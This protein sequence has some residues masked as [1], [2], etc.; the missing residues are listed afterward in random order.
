VNGTPL[1]LDAN[2][3]ATVTEAQAGLFNVVATATDP[4]GNTGRATATLTVIDPTD[5]QA[6]VVSLTTP[7]DGAIITAPT[8][9]IGTANDPQLVLYKLEVAPFGT[10]QFTEIARGTSSVVNGTLGRF[11]PTL[12]QNDSYTLRL[13][14]QNAGGHVATVER[15]VSVAGNLKLGNFTLT[16]TDLTVPVWGIPITITRTYDTLKSNTQDGLGYG[17]RLEFR[18]TDLHT[19]IPRTGQEADG[20]FNPIQD[21]TRVYL[22]EPGGR[23]VGFTF[24]PTPSDDY[25]TA[26]GFPVYHPAFVADAGVTDTLTVPDIQLVKQGDQY[27][28]FLGDTPYNP[29]DPLFGATYTLATRNGTAFTIDPVSGD[30]TSA[31]DPN[32]NTLTYSDAGVFSPTGKQVTLGRDAQ[33]RIVSVTD[34]LGDQIAYQYDANGDLVAATDRLGNTTR[35][36]YSTARPHYLQQVVGPQGGAG[37]RTEYDDQ[38]RLD[39]VIDP[40]G[41]AV[42]LN[43]DPNNSVETVVDA[44]GN[45]TR[46]Q[47]DDRGNIVAEVD[48]QGGVTRRTYDAN[49]NLLSETDPLGRTTVRTYD[50]AGNLLTMTDPLGNTTRSTYGPAGVLLTQTDALGETLTNTYDA[51]NH[52]LSSTDAAGNT[53]T[54]T[55]DALGRLS[56]TTDPAGNITRF[57]YDASGDEV[58]QTDPLGHETQFTYDANGNLLTQSTTVTT[59]AG[60]RTLVTTMAYDAEG[61]VTSTTDPEGHTTQ[62]RYDAL[63]NT[64][65]TT[66]PLGHETQFRYDAAGHKVETDFPDGISTLASFDAA[67]RQVSSTDQAGRITQFEYDSLGRQ[68]ATIYS[69]SATTRTEYNAAGQVTAQIDERGNRTEFTYDGDGRQVGVRNALGQETQTTYDAA[70]RVTA[71]TD[72]LGHTAQLVLDALGRA[73]QTVFADGSRTST[74]YDDL[75]RRT[76]VT[77]QAG[78]T[79]RF[80]YDPLGRLTAVVDALNRRTQY[81]Y[82]EVGNLVSQTDANGD[83]TRYEYDGVGHT[84]ATVLPLGQRAVTAYDAAGNVVTTTDY[85]GATIRYEYDANNRLTAKRLPDGTAFV[86]TYTPTGQRATVTDARGVTAYAYDPRDRLLSRTDPDGTQV[87]YSYDAAG[88]RTTLTDPAGTTTYTFD[89]LNRVQ[90]VTDPTAAVTRYAYDAAGNLTQTD[91]PDGTTETRSYDALN[92]L[93]SLQDSGPSG[94]ISGYRYVLDQAGN[95]TDVQ[96]DTGRAVRYIYDALYR[97]TAEDVT[98]PDGT[99]RTI[100]Y[101]YDNVGNRLT[102]ADSAEGVTSYTYDANDRLLTETLGGQVTQYAY[103]NNGNPLSQV[104]SAID[105]VVYHWNTQ[106]EL[107][108]ADITDGGGTRQVAY[109]YDADGIR[110]TSRVGGQETRYLIDANQPTAQVVLEY[111]PGGS[112][113]VAYVYGIDR[114]SQDRGGARSYYHVDGLA[115]T[116]ALT[117]ATGT[118]TDRYTYDAFGRLL[119]QTGTTVNTYLFAG[120]QRDFNVGLDYLRAR[121][122]DFSAGRFVGRDPFGGYQEDPLSLNPYVYAHLNPADHVD[123]SG[124]DDLAEVSAVTVIVGILATIG[125]AALPIAAGAFLGYPD[126][127]TFGV[128]YAGGLSGIDIS[129]FPVLSLIPTLTSLREF[130]PSGI[131]GLEVVFAPRLKKMAVFGW[132]GL[133]PSLASNPGDHHGPIHHEIGAYEAWFWHRSELAEK[134][135]S[136]LPIV[137]A[138]DKDVFAGAWRNLHGTIEFISGVSSETGFSIAGVV[139]LEAQKE[140]YES[141]LTQDQM[142]ESALGFQAGFDLLSLYRFD[143]FAKGWGVVG[144]VAA[145]A[146][147]LGAVD[148]WVSRTYGQP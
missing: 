108:G 28:D 48:A 136:F 26:L 12:L 38:G 147:N 53:T 37:V 16:F 106:N 118:V 120:E 64:I 87:Q 137:S 96:E 60:P 35:L 104:R 76:Q 1:A 112:N 97:L 14:A 74:A 29:S 113:E 85:N 135:A 44:L 109:Q 125:H 42:V 5:T 114:I 82:D 84:V 78:E 46:Y 130:G 15:T 72:P 128:F 41:H 39:R 50:A 81:A 59:P 105:Q 100:A 55:Y 71:Q 121:Y 115:S 43:Q 144:G 23:R 2:G 45:P 123:P 99:T 95:R 148:F 92:R 24:Q 22:T 20:V 146:I 80:E 6:P 127:V 9:V 124:R 36:V 33:G 90:T 145:T 111:S 75:G 143:V 73:V 32:G 63:G 98:N 138:G 79:T 67:G 8:D 129:R 19:F 126:M 140:L 133:E 62:T 10:D 103:D 66:D 101:T 77:D 31:T 40:A 7:A 131:V 54:R 27:F 52:L 102:R 132:A 83:V 61:R 116:R 122:M 110:V 51:A 70:G 49:N 93:V 3:R 139:G 30:L 89:A 141:E 47:Y 18:N 58:S 69:D 25:L 17:W 107:T 134:G 142:A 11:D 119:A 68:V 4:A 86:L 94:V 34:P 117:D 21:G 57:G 65:A 56:S 91:R 88:N 13:T